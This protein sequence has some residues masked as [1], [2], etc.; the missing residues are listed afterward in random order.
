[1]RDALP[2]DLRGKRRIYGKD[3]PPELTEEVWRLYRDAMTPL[4]DAGK[5]GAILMQYPSWFLPNRRNSEALLEAQA[6]LAPLPMA[7]ELRN[8][9][10]LAGGRAERFF[11]WL[12]QHE[13]TYVVVDEPQGLDT[14]VPPFAA[15]TSPRL[16][17]LR[18]HG[19]R[20]ETWERPEVGVLERFRY[21][22]D[23]QELAEWLPRVAQLASRAAETHV[24]MNTCYANYAAT[25]AEE[26]AHLLQ[27]AAGARHT[28]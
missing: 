2:A 22:Y 27:H 14:S 18:M 24:V 19:R 17:M 6:R 15:A 21:L 7:V 9:R 12:R 1:V 13:L 25:T 10:W 5:L 20:T 8:G 16:S 26:F 3:L 4:H 23:E 28:A 11:D